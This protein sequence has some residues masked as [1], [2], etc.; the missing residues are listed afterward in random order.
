[1]R[2]DE[3]KQDWNS[4]F[5]IQ[6]SSLWAVIL[7][8][9]VLYGLLYGP[10]LSQATF[11]NDDWFHI[12][13]IPRDRVPH[14]FYGDWHQGYRN[15]GGFYRPLPRLVMQLERYCF[16]FWT[17]G[18]LLVS[19]VLHALNCALIWLV[20]MR[21]S[22][23]PKA[24]SALNTQHSGLSS[25]DSALSHRESVSAAL[26]SKIEN[27]KSKIGLM[28]WPAALVFAI[29]PTHAEA[30]LQVSMLA[31]LMAICGCLIALLGY[32]ALRQSPTPRHW[33]VALGGAA[34]GALSKESWVAL[35]LILLWVEWV[36]RTEP[37]RLLPDARA[38][39][40]V[41][42]FFAFGLAYVGFRYA[43]LGGVG[44]YGKDLTL[45]S[46]RQTYDAVF[47][48]MVF[49]FAEIGRWS[50]LVNVFT[51]VGGMAIL[52]ALLRFSPLLLFAG[53]WM[54]L[55]TLPIMSLVPH[56]HDGGRLVYIVAVGWSLF[57]GGV[58]DRVVGAGRT[59]QVRRMAGLVIGLAV[60]IPLVIAQLR[61]GADWRESFGQNRRLI[62]EMVEIVVKQPPDS[63]FAVLHWPL[64]FGAALSNRPDSAAKAVSTL[65]GIE[66]LRID[67][68][69]AP[70]ASTGTITFTVTD[71]TRLSA[72]RVDERVARWQWSG[73]RLEEWQP[74]GNARL[75]HIRSDGSRDYEFPTAND[76][77]LSPDFAGPNGYYSVALCYQPV[78]RDQG[79]VMWCG[80]GEFFEPSR[81]VT[82][83]ETARLGREVR[84]AN[85]GWLSM[86]NRMLFL[87]AVK[88]GIVTV[89]SIEI[90]QFTIAPLRP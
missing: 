13:P 5:G 60:G 19:A 84:L 78:R 42:V 74:W 63:R 15:M 53:G 31:D 79:F 3:R 45:S 68:L 81:M 43:A 1:M 66:P 17:Q 82:L 22:Q 12:E 86:P 7:V 48:M 70:D 75:S 52:W 24:Q 8:C 89:R 44:G 10:T 73:N 67:S 6:C 65:A 18:Y 9:A 49:P 58:F 77:L 69:L 59:A 33:I 50:D 11:L 72:G 39:R 38:W 83:R 30:L 16:A 54:V 26:Q 61:T 29:Y 4:S 2:N 28:A 47:Q 41:S 56:L 88:S 64:R 87:P 14:L 34:L 46:V 37:R 90:A 21:L 27:R 23:Q 85:P 55:T 32:L 80:P 35:P 36:W 57:L 51:I 25:Q 20:A 62:G 71:D 40:R 76:G